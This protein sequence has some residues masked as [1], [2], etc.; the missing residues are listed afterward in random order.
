MIFEHNKAQRLGLWLQTLYVTLRKSA[1][2][3]RQRCVYVPVSR[4][5]TASKATAQK[6]SWDWEDCISRRERVEISGNGSQHWI[7]FKSALSIMTKNFDPTKSIL[8]IYITTLRH[9]MGVGVPAA[10]SSIN[11][12]WLTGT[13]T[14]KGVLK[15]PKKA[16]MCE[17]YKRSKIFFVPI[18]KEKVRNR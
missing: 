9:L 12:T 18:S 1:L 15:K 7:R 16:L 13:G 8:H 6:F 3:I 10:D 14:C 11:K 5:S 2:T 17:R 4:I